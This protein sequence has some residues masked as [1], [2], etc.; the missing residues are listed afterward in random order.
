VFAAVDLGA[1]SGR[2]VAGIVAD[3][4]VTLDEVHRFPNGAVEVDG[5][6]RWDLDRLEAEVLDGLTR[7]ARRYPQVESIGIDSWAVDYG[8][9]DRDGNLL[10]API[11]HR[12]GRTARTVDVVHRRVSRRELYGS[13]GLQFLPFTTLYQLEAERG[14]P[15]WDD[16][17]TVLLIPDLLAH[18]LTGAIGTE[19]TNASTTGLLDAR[20]RAW[21][22]PLIE[23]LGLPR[24]WFSDLQQPGDVRGPVRADLCAQ[25]G[26][27]PGTV[28]TCVG[29]HDTASA[30]VAV[31]TTSR[32][33]AYVSSGTWSLV[34]ME[35]DEPVL[36]DA[37]RAANVTNELGVDGRT[38]LLRNTGGLWLLQ[39]C[40][41]TWA[42][43]GRPQDLP[44]LLADAAELPP[45]PII[46]V[47]DERYL[48]PGAMPDRV[49]SAV[50]GPDRRPTSPAAVTRC[51]LESLAWAYTGTVDQL[52][53]LARR[54]IDAVHVVGGGSANGLLC[55]LTA[56]R[57]KRPV[58]AGPTEATAIGNVL[59]QARAH[60]AAAGTLEDLRSIV[61]AS[62][63][64]REYTPRR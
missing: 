36:T 58:V 48:A 29:S 15:R 10:G 33:A 42:D 49:A 52:P 64:L 43:E 1:S 24:N 13:N 59:V 23:R 41:R 28:V 11:S 19:V 47:A 54:R 51:V 38:R 35:L 4:T 39:E 26:L 16:I 25:L 7:L 5:H 27:R 60:G 40:L 57:M 63:D 20:T 3:G 46:G 44:T 34:G 50:V 55:Q 53:G 18:R 61:A 56:D 9:L 45:G 21:S 62:T 32:R 31:P 14:G 6:L 30:V 22:E 2:V 17:E 37:A 8:A 12:D